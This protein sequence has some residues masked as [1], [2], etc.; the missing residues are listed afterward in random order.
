MKKFIFGF[1]LGLIVVSCATVLPELILSQKTLWPCDDKDGAVGEFCY[2]S[3]AKDKWFSDKCK[4]WKIEKYN[5]CSP[6]TFKE[7]RATNMRL[8]SEERILKK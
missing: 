6:E 5:F 1:L 7:L 2:R 8:I 3:C 4:E